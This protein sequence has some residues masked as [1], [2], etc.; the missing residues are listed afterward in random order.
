[1]FI[2]NGNSNGKIRASNWGRVFATRPNR[3]RRGNYENLSGLG[4]INAGNIVAPAT[5]GQ[6]GSILDSITSIFQTAIPAVSQYR[7]MKMNE[8]LIKSGRPP[9]DP[10]SIAPV[11][12]VQAGVSPGIQSMT[13]YALIGTGVLLG[14]MLLMKAMKR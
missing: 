4:A 8:G 10:A 14:G 12:R 9:L 6:G 11:V 5:A 7:L 3:G 13:K 2:T 1:M